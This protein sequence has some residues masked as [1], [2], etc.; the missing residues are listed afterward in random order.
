MTPPPLGRLLRSVED[1]NAGDRMR[2]ATAGL[3]VALVGSWFVVAWWTSR[4]P[5]LA[6]AAEAV[7]EDFFDTLLD[8]DPEGAL[9]YTDLDPDRLTPEFLRPE[10][11]GEDWTVAAVEAGEPGPPEPRTSPYIWASSQVEV[12]VTVEFDDTSATGELV[13][14]RAEE[15]GKVFIASP[16]NFAGVNA[17]RTLRDVRVN[18]QAVTPVGYASLPLLPGV[19]DFDTADSHRIAVFP[20]TE[21]SIDETTTAPDPAKLIEPIQQALDARADGCAEATGL[22]AP[23]CGA[24][25]ETEDDEDVPPL[26]SPTDIEW[27]VTEYA[28]ITLTPESGTPSVL[29]GHTGTDGTFEITG[30]AVYRDTPDPPEHRHRF[31][32]TCT[33]TIISFGPV[34]TPDGSVDFLDAHRPNFSTQCELSA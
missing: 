26:V 6:P 34:I 27:K 22:A 12:S 28:Q 10:L 5:D 33:Y 4:E 21:L 18:G 29:V 30:S 13:V 25:L 7:V 17:L 8:G 1:Q 31:H 16:V 24:D 11:V 32:V 3:V 20:D 23:D 2:W 9:S 15:D 19:Y 14:A